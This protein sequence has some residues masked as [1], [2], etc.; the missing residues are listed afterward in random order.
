L[1]KNEEEEEE[2]TETYL[3]GTLD[4]KALDPVPEP[5]VRYEH[6][7]M[8]TTVKKLDLSFLDH[9]TAKVSKL[10]PAARPR[11][12][13]T[14]GSGGSSKY[15]G[16]AAMAANRAEEARR[17]A[18]I[19]AEE[20]RQARESFKATLYPL[21]RQM[22]SELDADGSG[23]LDL[24]ETR[25]LTLSLGLGLDD[26][27]LDELIMNIDTDGSGQI[28]FEE[29]F[30]WYV[31]N[32]HSAEDPGEKTK[33]GEMSAEKKE[34]I[35]AKQ[36]LEERRSNLEMVDQLRPMAKVMFEEMDVDGSNSLDFD[37][38]KQL[39]RNLGLHLD[40]EE[41]QETYQD[42]DQD[43]GGV[44]FDEFFIWYVAYVAVNG[45]PL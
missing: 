12:M 1:S 4:V 33:G 36:R 2:K 27:Q 30:E 31:T 40:E 29:F 44:D 8:A 14:F 19:A 32:I 22:F 41:L 23:L 21:V 6:R 42:M 39:T 45:S 24:D 18:E 9:A 25:Q 26:S 16:N 13:S 37:E 17:E 35:Q 5:E 3:E 43:G 28:D 7:R 34:K 20:E 11:Q 10:S 38:V 15:D